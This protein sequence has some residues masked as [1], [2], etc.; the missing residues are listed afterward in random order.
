[1][2]IAILSKVKFRWKRTNSVKITIGKLSEGGDIWARVLNKIM[3]GSILTYHEHMLININ[4]QLT[5]LFLPLFR[6]N[7]NQQ[8]SYPSQIANYKM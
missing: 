5:F 2:L 8:L 3:M 1:M 7:W 6:N 4:L